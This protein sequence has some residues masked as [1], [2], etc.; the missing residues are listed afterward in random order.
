[1]RFQKILSA[2]LAGSMTATALFGSGVIPASAEGEQLTFDIRSGGSNEVVVSAETL[3]DGDYSIPI[4]IFI[5]ENPGIYAANLKFQIN[6]GEVAEDGS[7]GNYGLYLSE[8]GFPE[9]YCFDSKNSGASA[10][11]FVHDFN[12]SQMNL[13]WVYTMDPKVNA[14]AAAE[15]GTTAWNASASWSNETP[16]ANATLVVPQ[17][18]APGTYVFDI[19]TEPY[20]NALSIGRDNPKNS[21][22]YCDAA[23]NDGEVPFTS[24]ALT[25]IVAEETTSTTT[26]ML[27][28]RLTPR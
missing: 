11:A 4:D 7:F 24:K 22:S 21:K 26:T 3:A 1:M 2:I 10:N 9:T 20:I 19:R 6:D 18:T 13:V 16:F 12:A 23:G 17:D 5:P 15:E 25:I 28:T 14:D 27:C 8:A